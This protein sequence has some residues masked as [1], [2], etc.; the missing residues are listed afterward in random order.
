MEVGDG[1]SLVPISSAK[2]RALLGL[3][4]LHANEVVSVE[5]LIDELWGESP[6]ATASKSLQVY[7]SR[8]RKALSANGAH[9]AD[10]YSGLI[11]SPRG[12]LIRVEPG[13]LD[14]Q[15]FEQLVAEGEAAFASDDAEGAAACFSAGLGLW[16]GPPLADVDF[17]SV[18][19]QSSVA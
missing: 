7:V 11:T 2:Q 1:E 14:L 4:L 9:G 17:G 19:R 16:R 15:R 12:Y 3:L 18:A 5:R 6:P 8:L 10:T 13:E